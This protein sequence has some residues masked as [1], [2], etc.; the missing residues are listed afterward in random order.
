[1]IKTPGAE[2]GLPL[3]NSAVGML[4]RIV[5]GDTDLMQKG[6]TFRIQIPKLV[7][8]RAII[9]LNGQKI[10]I[11]GL[12]KP[13]EGKTVTLRLTNSGSLPALEIV[14]SLKNS[15][16]QDSQRI[17]KESAAKNINVTAKTDASIGVKADSHRAI[18]KGN[19]APT[20][21]QSRAMKDNIIIRKATLISP[22]STIV[23]NK[24]E[25][26]VIVTQASGKK[27]L[28]A[29]IPATTSIAESKAKVATAKTAHAVAHLKHPATLIN[30]QKPATIEI[31]IDNLS[32]PLKK[33]E[34]L[35]VEMKNVSGTKKPELLLKT[36]DHIASQPIIST[37]ANHIFRPA[38]PENT[39]LTAKVEHRL[40]N[41]KIVFGWQGQQFE[42]QAPSTVKVGDMLLLK[43]LQGAKA[44][45]L[46]V[47]DLVKSLPDRAITLFKQR[48][49]MSEP[50]S[51]VLRSLIGASSSSVNERPLPPPVS[52][53]LE[54]LTTLLENYTVSDDKPLDGHRLASMI[55]SSGQLYEALLGKELQSGD[56]TAPQTTQKDIKAVLLKLFELTQTSGTSTRTVHILQA[57]EQGTARIESQQAINLLAFQQ[58]EPI[59]IE[60]PLIIQGMLSVVQ[61]AVS[62][63]MWTDRET[64]Q[65]NE[66]SSSEAFNILFALEL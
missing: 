13:L 42:A 1:M 2:F 27:A 4:F 15:D 23:K 7:Q 55:R 29:Q 10:T 64:N 18:G 25:F 28:L 26:R 44:P 12:P 32:S 46:E 3:R 60:F 59:R 53:Q 36:V 43:S 17:Q 56:S 37:K 5:S 30:Q 45:T 41:G 50:L 38:I 54:A 58:A 61:M 24:G 8:G 63:E 57:S 21:I 20:S 34:Q 19:V 6:E 65:K 22:A 52:T 40:P 49:G 66:A 47:I 31:R 33:G 11:E 48:I 35:L 51:Q 16:G 14:N 39:L 62:M 9:E